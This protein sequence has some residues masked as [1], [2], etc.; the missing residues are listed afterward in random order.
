MKFWIATVL[1]VLVVTIGTTSLLLMNSSAPPPLPLAATGSST[2]TEGKFPRIVVPTAEKTT[3]RV[4]QFHKG[5]TVFEFSNVGEIDLVVRQGETSCTCAGAT[6]RLK[7][8]DVGTE[9]EEASLTVP[10]GQTAEF[11]MDWD[12][13]NRVNEFTVSG[14]MH[15]NDPLQPEVVFKVTLDVRLDVKVS[16]PSVAFGRM[17]EG[18]RIAQSVYFF[19]DLLEDLQITSA[20]TTSPSLHAN[21]KPLSTEKL[22]EFKALS[23]AEVELVLDGPMPIGPFAHSLRVET[24]APSTK[25]RV[26]EITGSI[27]GP[28]EVVPSQAD[29]QVVSNNAEQ[30]K[31]I[32]VFAYQLQD[33]QKLTV[34]KVEP[35]FLTAKIE[36][37]KEFPTLWRLHI[38]IPQGAPAGAFEGSVHLEAGEGSEAATVKVKGLVSAAVQTA[39]T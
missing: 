30:S 28:F 7:G 16:Q 3:D 4:P 6:L 35:G 8:Q 18:R 33:G 19:S 34:S 15:T 37:D 25:E 14:S 27:Y 26:L 39:G 24:N 13:K 38:S 21:V 9:E 17:R 5:Q 11:V 36:Q 10:P 23:G 12:S 1:G 31:E 29:F 2:P 22:Q 20:T 32:K